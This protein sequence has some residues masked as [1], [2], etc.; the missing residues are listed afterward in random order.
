MNK[1]DDRLSKKIDRIGFR[2][3]SIIAIVLFSTVMS[4]V[5]PW[6]VVV[7]AALLQV[8]FLALAIKIFKL[9]GDRYA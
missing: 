7:G 2:F 9:Q 6:Y 5:V 3:V 8:A 4:Q 1:Q